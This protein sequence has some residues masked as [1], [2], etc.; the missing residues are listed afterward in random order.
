MRLLFACLVLAGCNGGDF[1]SDGDKAFT[2]ESVNLKCGADGTYSQE[3]LRLEIKDL[4]NV[5]MVVQGQFC[6]QA[7]AEL[8]LVFLV[9]FSL[10]MY[11][12]E[13][14]RGNDQVKDG[15]CGRLKAASA[16]IDRYSETL[17]SQNAKIKVGV[18]QFS[19]DKLKTISLTPI[20]DLKS[21]LTEDNFCGGVAGTNYKAAFEGASELLAGESG[22]KVLYLISDGLPTEGGGGERGNFP[23]HLEAAQTAADAMRG[24]VSNLTFNTVFLQG[25]VEPDDAAVDPKTFLDKLTGSPDRVK[26][27][28]AADDLSAEILALKSPPVDL[29]TTKSQAVLKADGAADQIVAFA[30]FAAD[31]TQ[32]QVW[33]FRTEQFKAFPGSSKESTL[34]VTTFDKAGQK[35]DLSFTIL[36]KPEK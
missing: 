4:S 35:Y 34:D 2:P 15:S 25:E 6:P 8:D 20:K 14:S 7:P 36:T 3:D 5:K 13:K 26:I 21:Q 1:G 30:E 28:T 22:T 32:D 19:A 27:A 23:R 31:P 33:R 17:A 12:E 24:A 10:S 11:N 29:D 16:I 18:V 9:D